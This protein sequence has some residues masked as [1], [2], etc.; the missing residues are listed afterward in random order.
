LKGF[1]I[2]NG[3]T[4]Y[5]FDP[6]VTSVKMLYEFSIIPKSLMDSYLAN[7]CT[8]YWVLL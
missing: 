2:A 3:A 8:V 1:I 5:R 7:N 6:H 4:D